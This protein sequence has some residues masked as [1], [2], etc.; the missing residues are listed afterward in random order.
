[1]KTSN[2]FLAQ[3]KPKTKRVAINKDLR[4]KVWIK[5][6][7]NKTEGKCY[8]CEIKPIHFTD[9][10]VGHNKAVANNGKNHITN[11]RPICRSCNLGMKTKSIEWYKKKYYSTTK[12]GTSK[13]TTKK[14]I[15]KKKAVKKKTGI[16]STMGNMRNPFG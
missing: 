4:E 12:K 5:Y 13:T 2:P 14:K 8:C 6:M 9:F 1:M 7:G 16:F 3:S 11:L 10:Y 15:V